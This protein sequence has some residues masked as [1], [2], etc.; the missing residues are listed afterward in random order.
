M[1]LLAAGRPGDAEAAYE[2]SLALYPENVWALAGLRNSLRAQGKQAEADAVQARL[3]TAAASAD[4]KL[5][6]SRF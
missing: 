5:T 6:A 2:E 1:A 4:V 3:D